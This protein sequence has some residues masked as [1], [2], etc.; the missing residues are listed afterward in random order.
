MANSYMDLTD[1][2]LRSPRTLASWNAFMNVTKKRVEDT[3]VK[4][5]IP[6]A[7]I[8]VMPRSLQS[9]VSLPKECHQ[10]FGFFSHLYYIKIRMRMLGKDLDMEILYHL[11]N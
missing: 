3:L 10:V 9:Q 1:T 2:T 11:G 8:S 4:L 6:V 5:A 7:R